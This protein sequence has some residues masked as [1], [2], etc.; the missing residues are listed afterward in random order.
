MVAMNATVSV[1][2]AGRVVLP[3]PVRDELQL[4]PGDSLELEASEDQI[5]LRPSRGSGRMKKE[6]GIWVYDSGKPLSP[7]LVRQTRHKILKDRER[8]LLG[9]SR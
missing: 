9:R 3:K 6:R 2:K 1:D 5:V 8:R 7:D 4:G